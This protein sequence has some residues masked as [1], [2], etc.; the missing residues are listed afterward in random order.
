M[1]ILLVEDDLLLAKGT[2]KLLERLGGHQ[3]EITADPEKIMQLCQGEKVDIVLMDVN[4]PGAIWEGEEVSGAD[5]SRLLKSQPQTA[6]IPII[7]LT[8]YAMAT[9][10][11][12]LL[13]NSRADEFCTK[14]VTDY[15]LL[16]NLIDQ[17]VKK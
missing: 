14:P 4:L 15:Q 9:E 8:A 10:R 7:I 6:H 3:V 12:I 17:L 13:N 5:L 2:A 16:L 11:E 1:N